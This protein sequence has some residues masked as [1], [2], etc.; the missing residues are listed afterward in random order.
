[1]ELTVTITI[2]FVISREQMILLIIG[3]IQAN[4]Y[5]SMLGL[6]LYVVMIQKHNIDIQNHGFPCIL[7]SPWL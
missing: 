1:M 3:Y 7:V 5:A 6:S 2:F 4:Y